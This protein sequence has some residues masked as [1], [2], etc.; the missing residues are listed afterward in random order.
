M[1]KTCCALRYLDQLRL[2]LY[3]MAELALGT[4]F[5]LAMLLG[6]GILMLL[7]QFARPT[8]LLDMIS[9]HCIA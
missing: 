8:E 5:C 1:H 3:Q 7:S 9:I 2:A 4:G 6:I